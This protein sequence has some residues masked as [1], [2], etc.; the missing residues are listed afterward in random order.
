MFEELEEEEREKKEARKKQIRMSAIIIGAVVIVGALG[1]VIWRPRPKMQASAQAP[2]ATRQTPS[3]DPVHDLKLVRAIMGKDTSGIRVMWSVQLRNRST[4]YTY[5]DIQYD[6]TFTGA[7]GKTL[8]ENQDTIK[9]T[10]GPGEE[11]KLTPFVDG[12]YNAGAATY[13]FVITGA[14]ATVQ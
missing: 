11:K 7:D 2:A 8:A 6:A 5:S 14:K 1:Y 12:I 13:Q 9:D 4:V 10:I 3:A